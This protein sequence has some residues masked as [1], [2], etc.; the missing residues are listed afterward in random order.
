MVQSNS[1][2]GQ[3]RRH[4]LETLE[5]RQYLTIT[6]G[7]PTSYLPAGSP[8]VGV[9]A[10]A[11]GDVNNDGIPDLVCV[12]TNDQVD[13]FLGQS[14]GTFGAPTAYSAG[15]DPVCLLL[16][17]LTGNGLLDIVVANQA[18]NTIG[19]LLNA[20]GGN[21]QP[22]VG[23]NVPTSSEIFGSPGGLAA[24]QL[25]TGIDRNDIV[26]SNGDVF[27]TQADGS[28]VL[29]GNDGVK[30]G[31]SGSV[32]IADMNNDGIN[33]VVGVAGN[34]QVAFGKGDGT[35]QTPIVTPNFAGTL[36]LAIADFNGNGF[37]GIASVSNAND[38]VYV[39]AGLGNGQF[40]SLATL[41]TDPFPFQVAAADLTNDGQTDLAVAT[42]NNS[43][44][45]VFQNNGNGTFTTETPVTA[46][47]T[48]TLVA[49]ADV[50][51][52]QLPDLIT[53][54]ASSS[55]DDIDVAL[56]TSFATLDNGTLTV[57]GTAGNDTIA[58]TSDGATLTAT[59]NG[60]SSPFLLSSIT[61]INVNGQTGNDLI[62][63]GANVPAAS[64]QGGP[65][66]D[67]IT[68]SNADNNT[69]GGGKGADVITAGSGDDLI[70]GGQGLDSLIAGT[71]NDSIFGGLGNDTLRAGPGDDVLN[72]GAGVN[73]MHT[74]SGNNVVFYAVN[75]T[76]DMIFA[77]AATN[78]SLFYSVSDSPI[79]KNGS[80]PPGNQT[81][82]P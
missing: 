9:Q 50:N 48:P 20:G 73:S 62:T 76:D 27:I 69:L 36:G 7:T 2:R 46:Q 79:I 4:L 38:Q 30:V 32:A 26:D 19:V 45:D 43:L 16:T 5:R 24:G 31:Q 52:D 67:T 40:S 80:I 81:L 23:Y 3:V 57:N 63:L 78:D 15:S 82:L 21:F 66:A 70:H 72:G 35:F 18:D 13:V 68:A 56:N 41:N 28:L 60:V 53:G 75:G 71:G 37:N 64:V 74:G 39:M 17:D 22:V 12:T 47:T 44:V 51:G 33:D 29:S 6:F 77:G 1:R 25:I 59:L 55:A 61:S 58:L 65:G 10:I 11:V 14:G 42:L 34:I 8:G 54:S 49:L